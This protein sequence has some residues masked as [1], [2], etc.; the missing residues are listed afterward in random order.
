M[1]VLRQAF[2]SLG[3]SGVATFLGSGNI[4]FETR[5]KDVGTLERKIGRRLQR[6]LGYDVPVFLRTPTEL[7]RSRLSSPSKIRRSTAQM[8]IS[9][10]LRAS[11]AKVRKFQGEAGG[12]EDENRWIPRPC[13]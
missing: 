4:V 5:T 7:R 3:F 12:A 2:E 6:A 13:T 8:S 1:N 9:S 11:L 10:F